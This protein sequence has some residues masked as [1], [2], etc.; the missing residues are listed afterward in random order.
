MTL[1]LKHFSYLEMLYFNKEHQMKNNFTIH[2]VAAVE[3]GRGNFSIRVQREF[4]PALERLQEFSHI[5]VLWWAHHLDNDKARSETTVSKPY[6]GAPDTLGIFATRSP[7]RPNPV[8]TTVC[9]VSG[10]D[11]K[12]GV[13]HLYYIDADNGSPVIDIKPYLP[14]ADRVTDVKTGSWCENWPA[15]LEESAEFDWTTVFPGVE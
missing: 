12:N 9:S 10:I 6:T 15:S 4:I 7:M 3:C 1:R 14:C 11:M 8:L 13:I 5:T 2:P